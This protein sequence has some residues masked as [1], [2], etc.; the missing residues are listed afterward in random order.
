MTS[1]L[2]TA[3]FDALIA[4]VVDIEDDLQGLPELSPLER[5][6]LNNDIAIE[7]LYYSSKIE[8]TNLTDAQI[9]QA[10]HGEVVPPP[11]R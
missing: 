8:G 5:A 4:K 9:D 11:E 7:H 1:R 3:N 10:I 6:K 2:N